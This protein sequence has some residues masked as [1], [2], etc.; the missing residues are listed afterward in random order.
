M[1]DIA[2]IYTLFPSM[3]EANDACH[4]LLRE[5]LIACANRFAPAISH[6]EWQGEM[7]SQEKYPVLMKASLDQAEN[8]RARLSELHSYEVPAILV[9]T[10]KADTPFSG[11][12]DEQIA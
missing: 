6:Y 12:V 8:A 2:M 1:S 10:A 3:I 9:W 5:K 11:W 7:Q 4:T